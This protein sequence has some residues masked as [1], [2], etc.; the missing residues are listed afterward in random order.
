M[1][2]VF[3][4]ISGS[5]PLLISVP[6]AGTCVPE[7]IARRFSPAA[8][9]L[10]DTD[11]YVDRLYEFAE[12][13]GV[14][15]LSANYSRYV[16]DLNRPPDD[17]ALYAG[18]TPGLIPLE[19]FDGKSIYAGDDPGTVESMERLEQFWQ[20]YH[21]TIEDE[22]KR[23]RSEHGYSLLLDAHSI[24]SS[25]PMLF[26]GVLPDLNLGSYEGRSASGGLVDSA[27]AAIR[28]QQNYSHVLDGR[29]KGGYI[30][31]HYGRPQEGHHAVQ[32]EISQATYMDEA[33]FEY[34]PGPANELQQFLQDLVEH[35]LMWNPEHE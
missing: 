22:M 8:Q 17:A 25:V 33:S 20:P 15:L 10:P 14:S 21:V 27:M 31:R 11:W 18:K 6:H 23:I 26:D 16:I 9:S 12:K 35:I 5:R 34:E 2:N 30:T 4:F 28:G 19:T 24:Q 1:S 7:Y 3:N 32:L 29:F 13:T